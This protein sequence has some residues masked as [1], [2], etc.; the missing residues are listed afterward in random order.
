M[1]SAAV[2]DEIGKNIASDP[3]LLKSVNGVYQFNVAAGT[4]TNTWTVD[5]KNAPGSVKTGPAPKA[6]VTLTIKEDDFLALTEGKLNGQQAFM[7]GKLK[8]QG[9]MAYAMK[10]NNLFKK[11]TPAAT[12][13]PAPTTAAAPPAP[14]T[15]ASTPAASADPISTTFADLAKVVASNPDLIKKVNGVYVFAVTTNNGE[16]KHWTVDLKNGAGAVKEGKADKA[17]CTLTLKEND[18]LELMS[19]KLDGQT[20]FMKGKLKIAGNMSFA[21]KLSHLTKAKPQAKL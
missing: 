11:K 1:A 14:T 21:M 3:S 9:N 7:Q 13:P 8:V 6:D 20:A 18:F 15:T 16:T 10:L 12:A 5:L 2:F 17:D 19:G 4:Q